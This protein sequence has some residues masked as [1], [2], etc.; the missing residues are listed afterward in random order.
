[1]FTLVRDSHFFN[2]FAESGGAMH[3][4]FNNE[5][6]LISRNDFNGNTAAFTGGA[7]YIGNSHDNVTLS[8][9]VIR[10]SKSQDGG[11]VYIGQFTARVTI[12]NS[13]IHSNEVTG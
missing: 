2:N 3:C 10:N 12:V 11:G 5:G 1:M 9:V 6:V 7:L 4:S 13:T 8:A